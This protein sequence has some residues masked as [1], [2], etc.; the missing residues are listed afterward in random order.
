MEILEM[1]A[2]NPEGVS[3]TGLFVGLLVYVMKT[4]GSVNKIIKKRFANCQKR[5][6]PLK[7]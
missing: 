5:L 3:F 4:N 2:K 6:T 1:L 7:I